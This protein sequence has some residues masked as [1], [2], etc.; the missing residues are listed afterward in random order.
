MIKRRLCS[1]RGTSPGGVAIGR[2]S[3]CIGYT[4]AAL[5]EDGT[6]FVSWLQQA[7]GGA[8]RVMARAVSA[9]GAA[10]PAVQ[11]AEGGRMGL[12]YPRISVSGP[13]TWIAWSD[14]NG[15][16]LQTARLKK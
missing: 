12:G 4:S 10:G 5:A 1:P 14:P 9:A 3:F 15:G 11:V 2:G 7:E 16:K 13:E 6:A 8:A